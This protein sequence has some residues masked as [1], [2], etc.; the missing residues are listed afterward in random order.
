[1][2]HD[3]KLHDRVCEDEPD[4]IEESQFDAINLCLNGLGYKTVIEQF[5]GGIDVLLAP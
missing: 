5:N 3:T 1:M 2:R 4:F